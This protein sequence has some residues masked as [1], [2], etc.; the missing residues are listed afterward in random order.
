MTTHRTHTAVM[1]DGLL[2]PQGT[3]AHVALDDGLV[4][5]DGIFEGMRFYDRNPR[6]PDAHLERL[7]T[8][9]AGAGIPVDA[10]LLRSEMAVF[11]EALVN[12]DCAVRLMITR[13]GIRIWREEPLPVFGPEGIGL[14]PVAHRVTPLLIGVKTLSYSANMRAQRMA[15][16]QGMNDALLY[17]VDDQVILEGPTTSFG[18]LDGDTLVF[19]P[20]EAG[21][22]DSITR[23]IATEAVAT[24]ERELTLD[25][26]AEADGAFLM[27]SYMEAVPV[28]TVLGV[29]TFDV[30]TPQVRAV[31]DAVHEASLAHVESVHTPAR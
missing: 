19:P 9:G 17:R 5:G 20:L 28:H 23:R 7:A 30:T 29:A 27:S 3:A 6:T 1:I 2:V 24:V 22:L 18:W 26:L 13:S 15:K 16:D 31:V 4:R 21:V 14:L 8:S 10:D 11:G 25:G 12:P